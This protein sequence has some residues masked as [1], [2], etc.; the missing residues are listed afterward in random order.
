[1]EAIHIL[2]LQRIVVVNRFPI[3]KGGIY[4]PFFMAGKQRE[5]EVTKA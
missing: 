3:V 5:Y 4:D 2:F 1:M